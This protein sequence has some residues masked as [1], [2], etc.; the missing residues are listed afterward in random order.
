M[1]DETVFYLGLLAG[2]AFI[3]AFMAYPLLRNASSVARLNTA[4]SVAAALNETCRNG[5]VAVVY[6]ARP[7]SVSG[8]RVDGVFRVSAS[9]SVDS[10]TCLLQVGGE[11]VACGAS[12]RP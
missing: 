4:Y 12:R 3:A 2:A 9:G 7:V 6:A 10:S 5:S 8:G 11:V 1:L